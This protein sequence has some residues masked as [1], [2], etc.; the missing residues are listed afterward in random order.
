MDEDVLAL[1]DVLLTIKPFN[2]GLCSDGINPSGYYKHVADCNEFISPDVDNKESENQV[3]NSRCSLN[4]DISGNSSLSEDSNLASLHCSHD[5]DE[6]FVP[7]V[8]SKKPTAGNVDSMNVSVATG[9]QHMNIVS[10]L[11]FTL[12]PLI[13]STD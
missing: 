6:N 5:E 9:E 12:Y 10:L 4:T 3:P 2:A 11:T 13:I 8:I 7:C 1:S